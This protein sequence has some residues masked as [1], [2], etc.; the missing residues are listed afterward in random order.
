MA[1][2]DRVPAA[3]GLDTG[4]IPVFIVTGFLGSGKTTLLNRLVRH[5]GL[6]DTAVVV[7][8]FGEIGIDHL[9]VESSHENTVLLAS[10]CLCCTVRGDLVDTLGDLAAKRDGG[11]VPAFARVVIETTG[12]ADPAPVLRTLMGEP[13]ITARYRLAGVITTV[14]A[15]HGSGQLDEHLESLKQ[16]AVADVVV[17]TKTDIAPPESVAALRA[18]LLQ[19]S[20]AVPIHEVVGGEVEPD[21][22]FAGFGTA[23]DLGVRIDRAEDTAANGAAHEHV[24]GHDGQDVNRHDD[25]IAAVSVIRDRPL[26]WQAVRTWLQ[27]IASLRGA[28]LLRV[29]GIINVAGIDTPVVVHGVQHVFDPP[30]RLDRW[31]DDDRR[32]R[33]VLI[34]R[35]LDGDGLNAA[36]DAAIEG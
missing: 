15:V 4:M 36:L 22:L 10:G 9:L 28:D 26:E 17:M 20:P 2:G 19:I 33:I 1:A 29:K 11:E 16:A 3:R 30:R 7:N 12:L 25:R 18:R 8:E 34:A 14:D 31:P 13:T 32:T 27:S 23:G 6:A 35:D 24:H 21:R 5:P